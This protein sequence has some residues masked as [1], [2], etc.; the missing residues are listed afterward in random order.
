M[1][2]VRKLTSA[3]H[4]AIEN[5]KIILAYLAEGLLINDEAAMLLRTRSVRA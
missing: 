1:C 3:S 4:S 2:G 5:H